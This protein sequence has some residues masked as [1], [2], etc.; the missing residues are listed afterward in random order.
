M[1]CKFGLDDGDGT[2]NRAEFILLCTVRLGALD[3]SL[4]HLINDRFTELDVDG[5]GDLTLCEIKETTSPDVDAKKNPHDAVDAVLEGIMTVTRWNKRPSSKSK[6]IAPGLENDDG[7]SRS[8]ISEQVSRCRPSPG[9]STLRDKSHRKQ[10][11]SGP[12][13]CN[14]NMH[15]YEVTSDVVA[16]SPTHEQGSDGP[17]G[18]DGPDGLENG[19]GGGDSVRDKVRKIKAMM[20]ANRLEASSQLPNPDPNSLAEVQHAQGGAHLQLSPPATLAYPTSPSVAD[21]SLTSEEKI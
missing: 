3:P 11:A 2:I 17:D 18:T 13:R 9:A 7:R 19:I 4:V 6:R 21:G 16:F 12:G 15:K 1:M 20:S 10:G 5:S 8:K 14:D